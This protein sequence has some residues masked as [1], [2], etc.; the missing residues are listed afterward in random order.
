MAASVRNGR[1][2]YTRENAS[3][4]RVCTLGACARSSACKFIF[5]PWM[6]PPLSVSLFRCGRNLSKMNE[7]TAGFDPED[8]YTCMS[9]GGSNDPPGKDRHRLVV[10]AAGVLLF[11]TS[12]TQLILGSTLK[13]YVSPTHDILKTF[14]YMQVS[15]FICRPMIPGVHRR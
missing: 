2:C 15:C 3:L 8:G 9:T 13:S 4:L 6:P 7:A 12:V 14:N 1:P 10:L 11:V 5:F